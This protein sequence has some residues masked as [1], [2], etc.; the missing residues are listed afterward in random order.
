MVPN[1]DDYSPRRSIGF[2]Q[3][4]T[5]AASTFREAGRDEQE[6]ASKELV[7]SNAEEDLVPMPLFFKKA[8]AVDMGRVEP[9]LS[10]LPTAEKQIVQ[11]KTAIR[12]IMDPVAHLTRSPSPSP[13]EAKFGRIDPSQQVPGL[14]PIHHSLPAY[15]SS[16]S[17]ARYNEYLAS[18]RSQ[19][20]AHLECVDEAIAQTTFQQKEHKT[21][22]GKRLASYWSFRPSAMGQDGEDAK[23]VEKR[24]R[25]ERLRKE[26]W[27][28]TMERYGWRG[29]EYY[30][31]LRTR[32]L[33]ELNT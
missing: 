19:L 24:E 8:V 10:P 3:K 13:P 26:G 33:A 21:R 22:Q 20:H 7:N 5:V 31:D 11:R 12:H 16:R 14:I 30:A 25:I 18:F 32:A 28:V 2:I 17:L 9:L 4:P 15:L 6:C 1:F 23:A 27:R 29:S